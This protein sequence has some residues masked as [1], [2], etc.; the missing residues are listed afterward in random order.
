M[1]REPI[2]ERLLGARAASL[3]APAGFGKTTLLKQAAKAFRGPVVWWGAGDLVDGPA[4]DAPAAGLLVLDDLH[5]LAESPEA[6]RRLD[7]LLAGAPAGLRIWLAGR[8][9]RPLA[10]LARWKLAGEL[11]E[12]GPA[13]LGAAGW[14]AAERLGRGPGWDAYMADEVLGH[15]SAAQKEFLLGISPLERWSPEGCDWL[16]ERIESCQELEQLDRLLPGLTRP[17]PVLRE[18]LLARLGRERPRYVRLMRRAALWESRQGESVRALTHA[19]AAGDAGL[20][21]PLL[22]EVCERAL[23]EGRLESVEHWL[24]QA[25]A[26]LLEA[27]PDLLL[28]AGE[29]LRRAGRP[30]RA[31]RWLQDAAV[32]FARS[33]TDGG[34]LKALCHLSLVYGELGEWEEAEAA[35]QQM[36]AELPAAGREQ[37]EVLLALAESDSLR[38][39]FARAE[40]RF[41]QAAALFEAAGHAEGLG[42]ALVGLG[43]RACVGLGRLEEALQELRRARGCLSG[44]SACDALLAEARLLLLMGSWEEAERVLALVRPASPSQQAHLCWARAHLAAERAN[45]PEAERLCQEGEACVELVDQTPGLEAAALAARGQLEAYRSG[46]LLSLQQALH[47]A[48]SAGVPLVRESVRQLLQRLQSPPADPPLRVQS[49]GPFR[50]LAGEREVP[51]TIWGR[52]QVR[53][54]LQ[55]LLFQPGRAATREALLNA[56]WP[57]EPPEQSRA[58]LRVVLNRLRRALGEM[59]APLETSAGTVRLPPAFQLDLEEF[60]AHLLA[61]RAATDPEERILHCRRGRS[62]CSGELLPDAF[63][64]EADLHRYRAQRELVELLQLWHEAS[65]K[66]G[67]SE[68][69]ISTLEELVD[70]EPGREET[71]CALIR[72]LL[73][74]GRRGDAVRRYRTLERWLREE[75]GLSPSPQTRAVWATLHTK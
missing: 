16:L 14:P 34:L 66:L 20:T 51:P 6:C 28:R 75:L 52:P 15:L 64:P 42:A 13:E 55:Y 47:L 40:K 25:P 68:E 45:L 17:H 27:L 10:A 73:K 18:W 50:V 41:R 8:F 1:S 44:A 7:R 65:L 21:I 35:L 43:S 63:W 58:R 2:I 11:V 61:A 32:G 70:L 59:G 29:A 23:Q 49:F 26:P 4:L 57:D 19:L 31:V 74:A 54:L 22:R 38:G 5:A 24:T 36:E 39:R 67:R 71:V 9:E 62:L 69:A 30:R 12:I 37:A 3:L 33:A 72:L 56:F 48:G 46:S 60:R 53:A